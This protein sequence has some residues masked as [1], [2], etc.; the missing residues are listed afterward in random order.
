MSVGGAVPVSCRKRADPRG[1]GRVR[2]TDARGRCTFEALAEEHRPNDAAL[3]RLA[4]IV[5]GVDLPDLAPPA[6]S[7]GV[8]AISAGFPG[9]ARDDSETID[10][11]AFLYDALDVSLQR[12]QD[13]DAAA[14]RA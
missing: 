14:G 13:R 10:R 12:L 7:A 1:R 11:A 8:R 9:V 3:R 2:H 6:D 4:R 5:H